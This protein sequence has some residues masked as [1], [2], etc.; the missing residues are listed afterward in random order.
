[1][2]EFRIIVSGENAG[3]YV[4]Q[5]KEG[6]FYLLDNYLYNVYTD[7]YLGMVTNQRKINEQKES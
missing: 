5:M 1:M 3:H 7:K 4:I 2:F 6:T